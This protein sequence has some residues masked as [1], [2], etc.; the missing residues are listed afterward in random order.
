VNT[1][2]VTLRERFTFGNKVIRRIFG[3]KREK[4]TGSWR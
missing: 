2:F 4:L 3:A 1:W